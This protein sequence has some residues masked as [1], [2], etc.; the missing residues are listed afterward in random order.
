[1]HLCYRYP[2]SRSHDI[3]LKNV[4]CT[5]AAECLLLAGGA[6]GAFSPAPKSLDRVGV[7]SV[8]DARVSCRAIRHAEILK[9]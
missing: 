7:S 6:S 1:M 8:Y 2:A 3:S 4:H 9:L 5:Y